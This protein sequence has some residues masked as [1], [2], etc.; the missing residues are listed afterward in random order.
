[1]AIAVSLAF[2]SCDKALD[3]AEVEAG[4]APK[5]GIPE[6]TKPVVGEIVAVDK[7]V[8]VTVTFSGY[9][10]STDSLELGFLVTTDPTFESTKAILLDPATIPA[11]GTVTVSIPV[12]VATKNYIRATASSVN[13][14]NFSEIVEVDVPAIPWY[15]AM[16]STY[17]G[18]A[19]SYWDEDS[20]SWPGHEI[21][22]TADGEANTITFSNFDALA[23]ANGFPSVITGT[24]DDATRTVTIPTEEGLFDVGL[25]AAGI[26]IPQDINIIIT[27]RDTVKNLVKHNGKGGVSSVYVEN[28]TRKVIATQNGKFTAAMPATS[29]GITYTIVADG[30]IGPDTETLLKC[31]SQDI[32]LYSGKKS[33]VQIKYVQP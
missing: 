7:K 33:V 12:T 17:S 19:Y 21:T 3:K 16:A 22:V 15:Q 1:M 31:E 24:Y 2:A 29:A 32:T 9:S 26:T 25:S 27:P 11:D 28:L 10:E 4:F 13:G 23:V 5:T 18:D 8:D 6:V 14:S 20:C 30:F